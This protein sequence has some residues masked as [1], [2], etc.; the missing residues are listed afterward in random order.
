MNF[1]KVA[2]ISLILS[3]LAT[4]ASE[5]AAARNRLY[6][7]T[8]CGPDQAYLCKLHGSFDGAPFH[9]NLAIHPA[10]IKTVNRGRRYGREFVIVCGSPA[11]PMVWW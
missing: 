6:P 10:C 4:V 5:P 3:S 7:V 2:I 8:T 9:Y 11:R 1:S